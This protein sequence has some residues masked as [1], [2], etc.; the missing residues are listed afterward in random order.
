MSQIFISYRREDSAGHAGRLEEALERHFGAHSVFR[1]VEDLL[2][3][4]PFPDA[5]QARLQSADLVLVLIGPH[6]LSAERDG[7]P[8]LSLP[9]DYVRMEVTRALARDIPVVPV[10]LDDTPMPVA[11]DLP[12]DMRPLLQRHAVRVSDDGWADDVARLVAALD[13]ALG[14]RRRVASQRRRVA[15]LALALAL[16]IGAAWWFAMPATP[17]PAGV[18]VADVRYHW[19]A[20]HQERFEFERVGDAVHG[21]ASFLGR[22]RALTDAH[23]DDGRLSFTTQ[24]ESVMDDESRVTTHRY[25]ITRDGEQLK[26]RYSTS[27]GFDPAP[28]MVFQATRAP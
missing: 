20:T 16:A 26:V 14:G 11:A 24:S 15:A 28:P 25:L 8:R 10:L 21:S 22:P 17:F 13:A 5:L 3:G 1:D 23:W 2:P 12:A 6:W 7:T 19:G 4:Q 9:D 27:G 18:W